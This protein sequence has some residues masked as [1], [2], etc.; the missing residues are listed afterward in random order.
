MTTLW[1]EIEKA[2]FRRM[3]D[4]ISDDKSEKENIKAMKQAR[5]KVILKNERKDD[6]TI[7]MP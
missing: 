2:A 3:W 4:S 1:S 5:E 7:Q 6:N